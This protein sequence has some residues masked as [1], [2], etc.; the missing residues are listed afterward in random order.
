MPRHAEIITEYGYP[1]LNWQ[2]GEPITYTPSGGSPVSLTAIVNRGVLET[3]NPGDLERLEYSI[4]VFISQ[5]DLAAVNINGDTCT[6]KRRT[7]SATAKAINVVD[8]I[9]QDG[10]VWLLGLS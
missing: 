4:A 8:I 6:L 9:S 3:L 2:H 5:D 10:G 7:D 1:T